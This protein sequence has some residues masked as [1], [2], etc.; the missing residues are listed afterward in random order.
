MSRDKESQGTS[1]GKEALGVDRVDDSIHS[2]SLERSPHDGAVADGELGE[3]VARKN[4]TLR[5]VKRIHDGNDIIAASAGTLNILQQLASDQVV[6]VAAKVRGMQSNSALHV[7][8]EKHDGGCV[9]RIIVDW[10]REVSR[11]RR[12]SEFSI[13][14][15]RMGTRRVESHRKRTAMGAPRGRFNRGQAGASVGASKEG[16]G[17]RDGPRMA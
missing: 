16:E 3:T 8:E 7:V 1:L 4:A 12:A 5:D 17:K 14:R 13:A 9:G 15:K 10:R 11:R 2:L 6:H